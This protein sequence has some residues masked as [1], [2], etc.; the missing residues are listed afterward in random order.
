MS[1]VLRLN[2]VFF[3]VSGF[4]LNARRLR[5]ESGGALVETALCISFVAMPLLLGTVALGSMTYTSIEVSNAAHAGAMYGMMSS[6]F[7]ADT[8]GVI[9]AAQ[10]EATD[11]GSNMTVTPTVY[12]ACSSAVG[13]M[14]YSSQSAASS[15]CTGGT[16]H[17]LQF[18]QVVTAATVGSPIR[19]PGLPASYTLVGTSVMEVEE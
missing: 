19:C 4:L 12:F 5:E 13:G 14:Q 2:T 18:V 7:A 1:N 17:S 9:G 8:A 15:A 10:G 6:T 11:L 3:H 16:N